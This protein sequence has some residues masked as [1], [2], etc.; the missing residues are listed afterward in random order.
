MQPG[1][2]EWRATEL[3]DGALAVTD[4]FRIS[5][6]SI[7]ERRALF[8]DLAPRDSELIQQFQFAPELRASDFTT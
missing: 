2:L 7:C 4:F 6:A 5:G 1:E 8:T 3:N